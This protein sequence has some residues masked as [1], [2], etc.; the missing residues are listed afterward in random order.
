MTVS[1][2]FYIKKVGDLNLKVLSLELLRGETKKRIE[3]ISTEINDIEG[4]RLKLQETL[5]TFEENFQE[6]EAQLSQQIKQDKSLIKSLEKKLEEAKRRAKKLEVDKKENKISSAKTIEAQEEQEK[7]KE[8]TEKFEEEREQLNA[9][10]KELRVN[11][12][13]KEAIVH[14]NLGVNFFQRQNFDSAIAEYEKAVGANPKH[15]PTRYNLGILYEEYKKDY[16]KAII[17]YNEYILL[18]PDV[19]D[20]SVVRGWISE[21]KIKASENNIY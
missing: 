14:Y 12:A 11:L 5:N 13:E 2:V 3:S 6:K 9:K 1:T 17:H 19:K 10:I 4:Q 20:T 21:L 15:A 7:L 18:N 8:K 16:N